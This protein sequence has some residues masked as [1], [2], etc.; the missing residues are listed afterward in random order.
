MARTIRE[1]RCPTCGDEYRDAVR[2]CADC[3]V[4]LVPQGARPLKERVGTFHPTAAELVVRAA[5]AHGIEPDTALRD[6]GV[7]VLVEGRLVERLRAQLVVSWEDLLDGLDV[8]ERAEVLACGGR[9][10]GW[11]DPPDTLWVDRE[12]VLQADATEGDEGRALGP[13][14]V[15]VG[16]LL[17]VAAWYAGE[18]TPTLVGIVAGL[19]ILLLGVFLPR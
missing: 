3:G 15:S 5:R 16:L 10:P 11:L 12:G 17:L 4:A 18:G 7:A 8:D 1:M 9:Y 14:L 13:V 2:L 19:G 6:D